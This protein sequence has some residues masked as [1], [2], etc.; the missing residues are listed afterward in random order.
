[1]AVSRTVPCDGKGRFTIH[2]LIP[3]T[4]RVLLTFPEKYH[5]DSSDTDPRT[6]DSWEESEYRN[7]DFGHV[8]LER[9]GRIA[10]DIRVS[11]TEIRG[12][13]VW[14]ETGEPFREWDIEVTA[15]LY[16][17]F[18]RRYS[19]KA[20]DEA[21]FVLQGLPPGNYLLS[22]GSSAYA[23]GYVEHFKVE[24]D[25]VI[26]G[27]R[28]AVPNSGYLVIRLR[29]FRDTEPKEF[30]VHLERSD[31]KRRYYVGRRLISNEGTWDAGLELECGSWL[32]ILEGK[33]LGTIRRPFSMFDHRGARIVIKKGE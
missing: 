26:D 3:G 1:M 31:G 8:A 22:A 12:L 13:V 5:Y 21:R 11:G 20:D 19:R 10:R 18:Q 25:Q 32:L 24:K 29:G 9:P 27:V 4:Y 14:E 16:P 17:D 28:I 6:R 23:R 2:K 33:G 15:A 7:Y 30:E